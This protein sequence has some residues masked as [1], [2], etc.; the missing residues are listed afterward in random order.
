VIGVR[1]AVFLGYTVTVFKTILLVASKA[2][3]LNKAE[4]AA[5]P[6]HAPVLTLLEV[7]LAEAT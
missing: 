4:E 7:A 6:A 2:T 1:A 3:P 5:V